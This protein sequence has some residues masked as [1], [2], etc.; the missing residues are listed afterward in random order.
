MQQENAV[1]FDIA[2]GDIKVGLIIFRTHMFEHPDRDNAVKLI[3]EVTVILQQDGDIQT[4][5]AFLGEFLL[6]SGNRNTHDAHA[7]MPGSILG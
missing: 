4:F 7:I 2:F 3:V 5:A 6:F 1:R